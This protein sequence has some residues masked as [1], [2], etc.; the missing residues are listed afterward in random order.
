MLNLSTPKTLLWSSVLRYLKLSDDQSHPR[1]IKRF[2]SHSCLLTHVLYCSI[3]NPQQSH[4]QMGETWANGS[5]Y[6]YIQELTQYTKP[7]HETCTKED[8]RS[9]TCKLV[10]NQLHIFF[11]LLF[12]SK[13][14]FYSSIV[15]FRPVK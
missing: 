9:Q 8:V 10:I 14:Q 6:Q 12:N 1:G 15:I 2:T 11:S 4:G 5:S 13:S 3:S 7:P